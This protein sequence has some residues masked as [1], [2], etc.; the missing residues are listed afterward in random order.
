MAH[1]PNP[2]IKRFRPRGTIRQ[3]AIFID[4]HGGQIGSPPNR[5][6]WGSA[7]GCSRSRWRDRRW[8]GF[9]HF[10]SDGQGFV[11]FW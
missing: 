10:S 2:V 4:R 5:P 11:E 9:V 3:A 1:L 8:G 7:V 6:R